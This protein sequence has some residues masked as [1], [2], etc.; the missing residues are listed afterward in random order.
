MQQAQETEYRELLLNY[1][2]EKKK[3]NTLFSLRT[4]AKQLKISPAQLSQFISGKRPLTLRVALLIADKL[5]FSALEKQKMLQSVQ[6]GK[7]VFQASLPN[8]QILDED[9]FQLISEWYHFAILS[10][11]SMPNN[12]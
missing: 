1:L 8:Y 10:L 6:G 9:Q 2:R 3:K 11:G 5:E 4:L 7:K 12:Q